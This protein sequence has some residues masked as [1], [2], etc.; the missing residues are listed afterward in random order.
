MD[1]KTVA[2]IFG[3]YSPEYDVSLKSAY[4]IISA[5]DRDKYEVILVGITRQ[6]MWFR[7]S[8]PI[9][10]IPVDRW[11]AD[12]ARLRKAFISPERGG[13][14]LE[15]EDERAV[16]VPVDVV[17]PVLHGRYGEDGTIQGLCEL[18]GIPVVGAGAASSALCMDKDRSHKLVSLAG[19]S[20]PKSVC[21]EYL[22]TD[23][24]I[25]SAASELKLPLFVKPVKAGSS[26]GITKIENFAE[27]LASVRKAL[28]F[29]DAVIIEESVDGF[30]TGCAVVG[31]RELIVGR[32]DEI[33]L[34]GGFFDYEEK[35][36]LKTSKIH[37]PARIDEDT[38]RR[39]Q[40]AAKVIYRALGCRGYCRIDIFLSSKGEI[41][42]NEANTIPGF[43]STSRFPNMMKAAGLEYPELVDTLIE[44]SL[45]VDKGEWYGF[46][47]PR[48]VVKPSKD[49]RAWVEIDL[50]A[51]AHNVS[52][53]RALLPEGCELMAIVKSDAYG[54]GAV[55]CAERL[56]REG[57]GLFAVA[58]VIEG[59]RLRDSLAE[60]EILIL[61][62][63]HARDAAFLNAYNL[64]QLVVDGEHAKALNETGYKLRV[65]IAVDTGMHRLGI[66]QSNFAE[67][68]S[69][70]ACKNLIIE[71]VATHFASSDSLDQADVEFTNLQMERFYSVV[72]A[73]MEKGYNVGKLHS[74]ASYGV[75]NY[76]SLRCDFTRVGIALFGLL[77]SNDETVVK[78]DLRPVLSLKAIIAQVRWI[79]AGESVSYNRTFTTDKPTK[80][81]TVSVG[82]ADGVPRQLSGKGGMCIINGCKVPII[83]RICM[84]LLVVDVTGI[85][86]VAAGDVATFIGRDGEEVIRCEDFAAASG[87]ITNEIL[88]RLSG[89]LPRI[90][91]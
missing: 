10:D 40:S 45:S 14:L 91:F 52:K 22:P 62:Y 18:A 2:V 85:E 66:E 47:A 90:Y 89:R 46:D 7:Y 44:L 71:G 15:I 56:H 25:I 41:I 42:F 86:S 13:G 81:A 23:E 65:H 29:D 69:V 60:A 16:S 77:S 57:V 54:H 83:G 28:S 4:S 30:E 55:K 49:M 24:E 51:L 35:Y 21:F 76:R 79:E 19:I 32:I 82:Y 58:T 87:T 12:E 61:G 64:S 3:G 1:K 20:V 74:Q 34:A 80:I 6:G 50:N 36:T 31:N 78:P 73:L 63:T 68:E 84:D 70:Y 48:P 37:L 9:E 53:M 11:H 38:E 75:L 33:E 59:V 67:I 5:I 39:L 43:T 72:D 8:G 26:F 17:F 27:L 88:S